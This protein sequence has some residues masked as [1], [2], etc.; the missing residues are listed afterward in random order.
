MRFGRN[1]PHSPPFVR[2]VRPR[3]LPFMNGGGGHITAGGA[4]CMELLTNTG[5]SPVSSLESV[6]LQVR[7][8]ICSMD[9]KPARLESTSSGSR[10][11]YGV[12]EAFEAYKRAA[13]AH[14]WEVPSDFPEAISTTV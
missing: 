12:G 9:P 8:A 2:V 3:F 7:L 4:M 5:W 14:G 6:L 11:D 1:Y 13:A 10:H